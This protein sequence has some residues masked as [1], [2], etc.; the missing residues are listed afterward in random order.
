MYALVCS[1]LCSSLGGLAKQASDSNHISYTFQAKSME[2]ALS[3][4]TYKTGDGRPVAQYGLVHSVRAEHAY[5]SL[6]KGL[7][8]HQ[9]VYDTERALGTSH[10]NFSN[11]LTV[12]KFISVRYI[13]MKHSSSTVEIFGCTVQF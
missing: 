2:Q 5:L 4:S 13:V 12:V 10:Q 1:T 9:N 7:L 6:P 8:I 3:W 11:L